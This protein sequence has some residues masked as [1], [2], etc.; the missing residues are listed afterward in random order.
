MTLAV[1][2]YLIMM[3]VVTGDTRL[4]VIVGVV[5]YAFLVSIFFVKKKRAAVKEI[6]AKV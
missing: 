1:L 4:G 6:S 2:A 5:W 3:L